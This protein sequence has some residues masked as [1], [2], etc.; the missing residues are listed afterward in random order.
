MQEQG[1]KDK[2]VLYTDCDVMFLKPI[3]FDD[4]PEY[5]S[6]APEFNQNNWSYFN[7]GSMLINVDKMH[8]TYPEFLNYVKN[9]GEVINRSYDQGCLNEFYKNKWSRLSPV[10]N[11]KAYWG[12]NQAARIIHFHGLKIENIEKMLANKPQGV[13]E[14]CANMY[15]NNSEAYKTYGG[16]A[17][18]Y[19]N[20]G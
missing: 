3:S 19:E 11:W 7:S 18:R 5:F 14:V 12:V 9:C 16:L 17:K 6:C 15:R 4:Y 13:P 2:H 20:Y 10:F 8:E 1:W